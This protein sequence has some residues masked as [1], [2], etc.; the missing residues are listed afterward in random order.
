MATIHTTWKHAA[1][2][3]QITSELT[4]AYCIVRAMF[5]IEKKTKLPEGSYGS[6]PDPTPD[7]YDNMVFKRTVEYIN[8]AFTPA[9]RNHRH[10][11]MIVE[12]AQALKFDLRVGRKTVFHPFMEGFDE[13]LFAA[14]VERLQYRLPDTHSWNY[15]SH[16]Y[17]RAD[18]TPEYQ[19]VQNS[20]VALVLGKELQ[21]AN[22]P[23]DELYFW[24]CSV[25]N[26]AALHA[27]A[28][29]LTSKRVRFVTFKEPDINNEM[30]A[31]ATFPVLN[32]KRKRLFAN[33][34]KLVFRK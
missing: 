21:K 11:D 10:W 20:H 29:Y 28:A 24:C 4:L 17:V 33:D 8:I 27:K 23:T 25:P 1:T 22:I 26:E 9:K 7:E 31:I 34:Q 2:N 5:D 13:K 12:A 19:L 32:R 15:Y 6:C 16:F 3:K 30:T 18:L 14:I